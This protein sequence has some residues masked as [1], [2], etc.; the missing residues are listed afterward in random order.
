LITS[1]VKKVESSDDASSL[2]P[3][4]DSLYPRKRNSG[5][6]PENEVKNWIA[7][8]LDA[9]KASAPSFPSAKYLLLLPLTTVSLP[10]ISSKVNF[11]HA[12]TL[13][14]VALTGLNPFSLLRY[15]PSGALREYTISFISAFLDVALTCISSA[16]ELLISSF[17]QEKNRV[18]PIIDTITNSPYA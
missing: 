12:P 9:V 16:V 18:L 13:I 5:N 3:L 2:D 14:L 10:G 1:K 11:S 7:C 17:W 8:S 6:N 4:S 15:L